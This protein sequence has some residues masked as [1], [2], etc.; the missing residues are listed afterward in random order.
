M[1]VNDIT[2]DKICTKFRGPDSTKLYS[3]GH[4]RIFGKGKQN[5]AQVGLPGNSEENN[6]GKDVSRDTAAG[7]K[8]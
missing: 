2:G 1:S 4:D 6:E 3:E 7:S 5:V 8:S